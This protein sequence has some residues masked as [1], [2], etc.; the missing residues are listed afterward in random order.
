MRRSSASRAGRAGRRTDRGRARGARRADARGRP[1][2][3]PAPGVPRRRAQ[4]DPARRLSRCSPPAAARARATRSCR[5]SSRRRSSGSRGLAPAGRAGSTRMD[6]DAR[7]DRDR[8]RARLPRDLGRVARPSTRAPSTGARR[9][10]SRSP[11]GRSAPADVRAALRASWAVVAAMLRRGPRRSSGVRWR[12]AERMDDRASR[13]RRRRRRHGRRL[14]VRFS[15]REDGAGRV[16]VLERG[17]AGPGRAAARPASS[18][19]RAVRPTTV[20]LGRWSIDFYNGQ[21]ARYGTDSGFRELGYLILA[22]TERGRARRPRAGRDAAGARARRALARARPRPPRRTRPW[23]PTATAAAASSTPTG[24]S[25]RR[26]TCAPTRWRCSA[27]GVEL[28]ER[29][30]FTGLRIE[31]TGRRQRVVG[32]ETIG[33]PDRDGA[34]PPDRR[35]DAPRGRSRGR[36]PD[37]GGRGLRHTVA[38]TEPHA[39]FDVER[40]PMVFDLGAGPVLAARG[41]RPAVRLERPGR[42]AGRGPRRSTGRTCARMRR[43]A[44]RVRAGDPR[45]RPA[46][47]LGGHDR[48]HARPSADPRARR[49]TPDGERIDGPDGRLAGRPRDDVGAGRRTGRRRSR[50][51]RRHGPG[52]RGR[53]RSRS[54]RCRRSEP[55]SA[56]PDRPA[57]PDRRGGVA[58]AAGE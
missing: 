53:P 31:P 6:L 22:V 28:R 1:R 56:R 18:G 51:P 35:S 20:A 3:D 7:D 41:G 29:T 19:P 49:S 4:G 45:S 2:G 26:A 44:G 5:R 17:L 40:L 34:G 55:A 21:A 9:R 24:R 58:G 47:D 23:R 36:R 15:P 25:T 46:Q 11:R 37:P 38:V 30:A 14:G 8:R 13:S 50:P 16:V 27:A 54:V 33:R 10:A 43:A 52:R 12:T 32:V 57:L 48:L 42:A 39:A